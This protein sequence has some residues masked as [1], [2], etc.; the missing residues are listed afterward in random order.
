MGSEIMHSPSQCLS[1]RFFSLH[2]LMAFQGG[3]LLLSHHA[4]F[5]PQRLHNP[6][7]FSPQIGPVAFATTA[8]RESKRTVTTVTAP[9]GLISEIELGFSY[10][11]WAP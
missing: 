10:D 1:I 5:P 2:P 3:P 9:T 4:R 7:P 11:V 6:F 8:I